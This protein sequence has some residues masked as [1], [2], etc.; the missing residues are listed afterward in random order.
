MG[1]NDRR[2]PSEWAD[3]FADWQRSGE[4][5]RG[6]C[7]RNSIGFSTFSYWRKKLRE[8]GDGSS[9]VKVNSLAFLSRVG[10]NA[11]TIHLGE[12]QVRLSGQESEELL[13]RIF[14]ALKAS[15]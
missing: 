9:L 4:S 12:I 14:K 8:M 6:Y 11:P 15:L 13:I 5:Q 10:G 7:R 2:T 1:R 3:I